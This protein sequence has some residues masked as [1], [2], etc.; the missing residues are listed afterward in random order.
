V[1]SGE[2][3]KI[4]TVGGQGEKLNDSGDVAAALREIQGR[5]ELE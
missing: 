1:R 2:S 3:G 4:T 5:E